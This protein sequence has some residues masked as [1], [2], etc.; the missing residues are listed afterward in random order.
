MSLFGGVDEE[1]VARLE[2]TVAKMN[3]N[4]LKLAEANLKHIEAVQQL[5]DLVNASLANRVTK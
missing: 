2:A 4:I 1:R 5:A 3:I